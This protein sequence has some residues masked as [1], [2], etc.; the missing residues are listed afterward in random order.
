MKCEH[1]AAI[2]AR[3]GLLPTMDV[4][5]TFQ[6]ELSRESFS[7]VLVL[8]DE[9]ANICRIMRGQLIQFKVLFFFDSLRVLDLSNITL[10]AVYDDLSLFP[11]LKSFTLH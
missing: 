10:R 4:I 8:T 9:V 5:M 11:Y 2:L 7:T 3:E 1:F 6:R